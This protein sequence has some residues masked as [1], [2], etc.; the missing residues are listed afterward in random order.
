MICEQCG[1]NMDK[2]YCPVCGFVEFVAPNN[3]TY[4]LSESE[5]NLLSKRRDTFS[6]SL[7]KFYQ[8]HRYLTK[9]QYWY[10]LHPEKMVNPKLIWYFVMGSYLLIIGL[11]IWILLTK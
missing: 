7:L 9:K 6:K 11:F 3:R 10:V 5:L 2:E 8:I 1:S 4:K